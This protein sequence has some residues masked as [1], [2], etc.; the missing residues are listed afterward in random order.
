MDIYGQSMVSLNCVFVCFRN[1]IRSAIQD[2]LDDLLVICNKDL[3]SELTK[4]KLLTCWSQRIHYNKLNLATFLQC[5]N[6]TEPCFHTVFLKDE[7][8]SKSTLVL[9][10][11]KKDVF[12][13]Q[14]QYKDIAFWVQVEI[15]QTYFVCTESGGCL[16][17]KCFSFWETTLLI[18]RDKDSNHLRLSLFLW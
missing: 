17:A 1:T 11:A 14:E 16:W 7:Y 2:D 4:I 8:S 6:E 15:K 9:Y 18:R 5:V 12:V 10:S 13:I 3:V